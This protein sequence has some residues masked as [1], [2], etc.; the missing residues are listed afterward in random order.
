MAILGQILLIQTNFENFDKARCNLDKLTGPLSDKRCF[1]RIRAP[2][3]LPGVLYFGGPSMGNIIRASS[4]MEFAS[5]LWRYVVTF[6]IL[7]LVP[8]GRVWKKKEAWLLSLNWWTIF[9]TDPWIIKH[10]RGLQ[11]FTV[12]FI[13]I[14]V[15]AATSVLQSLYLSGDTHFLWHFHCPFYTVR[16]EGL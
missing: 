11:Q 2:L 4:D 8:C 10:M 6:R 5:N 1:L 3:P 9:W 7:L 16:P 15:A 13:S 14:I 12:F